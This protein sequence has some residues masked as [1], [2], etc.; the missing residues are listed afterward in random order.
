MNEMLRKE[1]TRRTR[2]FDQSKDKMIESWSL[3]DGD[4]PI[5]DVS[6]RSYNNNEPKLQI[7]PRYYE[8]GEGEIR[9]IKVG[10]LSWSEVQ[11][12]VKVLDRAMDIMDKDWKAERIHSK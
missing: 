6:V 11:W 12:L 7:G 3:R 5:L 2:G 1:K 10:R 9:P 4:R 8:T